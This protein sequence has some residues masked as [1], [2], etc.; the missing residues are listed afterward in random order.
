MFT[1]CIAGIRAYYEVDIKKVVALST[2]SQLGVMI[3]SLRLGFYSLAFFH[4]VRH[5]LFK[6]LLFIR[7]GCIIHNHCDW[8]DFRSIRGL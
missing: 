1:I 5:A 4:L 7:V 8:Q 3:F 2:L 6:A